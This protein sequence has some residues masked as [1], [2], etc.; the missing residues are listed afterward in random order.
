MTNRADRVRVVD[1]LRVVDASLFPAVPCANTNF[2]SLMTA[3][4]TADAVVDGR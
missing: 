3:D 4:K 1:G 2:L